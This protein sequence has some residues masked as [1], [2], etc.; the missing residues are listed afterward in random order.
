M[1]SE[2]KSLICRFPFN[3]DFVVAVTVYPSFNEAYQEASSFPINQTSCF[4]IVML[5]ENAKRD[6]FESTKE[7]ALPLILN[8]KT[9]VNY[10]AMK[11]LPNVPSSQPRLRDFCPNDYS[12]FS[13]DQK[14]D[15]FK[16]L[17]QEGKKMDKQ[18]IENEIDRMTL[19][20]TNHIYVFVSDPNR[21]EQIK[22]MNI[23]TFLRD[24]AAPRPPQ[25]GGDVQMH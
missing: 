2:K 13:G 18:A 19:K 14:M 7:K 15:F 10:V 22:T 20:F 8:A 16:N 11:Y 6:L 3:P 9:V 1:H 12:S 5:D 17:I 23:Y 21:S 24:V 4:D 25:F